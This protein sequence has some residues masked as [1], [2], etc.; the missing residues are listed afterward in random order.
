MENKFYQ[1]EIIIKTTILT[2]YIL[3]I[4]IGIA[5]WMDLLKFEFIYVAIGSFVI[6]KILYIISTPLNQ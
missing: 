6:G 1:K 3:A 4:I 5:L 2:L